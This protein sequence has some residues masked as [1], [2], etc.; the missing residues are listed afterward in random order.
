MGGKQLALLGCRAWPPLA[1]LD[2]VNL[3]SHS[4]LPAS[5]PAS[6]PLAVSW[7]TSGQLPNL[8]VLQHL[9]LS[10]PLGR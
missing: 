9:I 2:S 5:H 6:S 8:S 4:S 3:G 1:V 10:E 7:M